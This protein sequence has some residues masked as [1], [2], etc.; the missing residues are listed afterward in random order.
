MGSD[1]TTC[2]KTAARI[3]AMRNEEDWECSHVDCSRR[4]VCWSGGV[5]APKHELQLPPRDGIEKLFD[6]AEV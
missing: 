5:R 3:E 4:R 2:G 1:C 6:V